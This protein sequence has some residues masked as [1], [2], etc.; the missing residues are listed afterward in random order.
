MNIALVNEMKVVL[1]AMDI[2]IWQVVEAARTKPFGFQAFYPG[3]GAGGGTAF[4]ST[5]ST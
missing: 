4:R 1:D 5:R 3:P 2:D